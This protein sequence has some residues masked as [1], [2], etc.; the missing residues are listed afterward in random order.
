MG[1][2]RPLFCLFSFLSHNKYSTKLTI[3]DKS[4]VLET[5]TQG[6]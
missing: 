1:Q 6:L 5:Q 4:G 2:T 3:N